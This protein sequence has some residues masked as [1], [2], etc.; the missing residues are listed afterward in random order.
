MIK[1]LLFDLDDTL[2]PTAAGMMQEISVR[3]SDFMVEHVG[4]PRSDV[5]RVRKEYWE[6]YGTSLRGLYLEKRIDAQAFLKYVHDV[7]IEDYLQRDARLETMLAQLPQAKYIF[8]NA[9][10]EYA[11]RVLTV[12]GIER[13]FVRIFDI[14]FIEYQSKPTPIAYQKVLS[15]LDVPSIECLLVDDTTRNL[16]P[17]QKLGIRTVLVRGGPHESGRDGADAVI[18]TI[19]DLP[20]VLGSFFR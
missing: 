4:I 19:Y 18:D 20:Q 8:T 3:M 1:D 9:P 5:D 14:N 10:E 11:R 15:V 7:R 2:Y 6:R 16:A 13:F 17:A 12:L